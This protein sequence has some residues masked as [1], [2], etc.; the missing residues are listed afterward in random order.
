MGAPSPPLSTG[1]ASTNPLEDYFDTH[2]LGPGVFKWRHYFPIYDRHLSRFRDTPVR[3]LEIGVLG[4]G[5]L[6]M[7]RHYFGA[8]AHVTGVDIDP[9]CTAL[10]ADGIDIQ[11]GDQGDPAFW[12]AFLASAPPIDIVIDDGGHHPEQQ[13]ATLECLLPHIRAGGVYICEDIH[14][15]FQ[16]FQSFLD[17]LTR[18]LSALGD[19]ETP[20]PHLHLH[21]ASVHRYPLVA[22]IEKPAVSSVFEA[23]LHGSEWPAG[24]G[25]WDSLAS[26]Q[27]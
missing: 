1:T 6:H 23:Q 14:G 20:P 27:R 7:W 26:V 22:V 18:P 12:R 13:V 2:V 19:G 16:P 17:G 10:A 8:A 11:I 5:S 24:P 25:P 15:P 3:I 4:G 21:V 9:A